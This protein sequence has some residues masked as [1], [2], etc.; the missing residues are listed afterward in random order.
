MTIN[1]ISGSVCIFVFQKY[2]LIK[3]VSRTKR[4][5]NNRSIHL[6]I[7]LFFYFQT[8][9]IM[10]DSWVN[11][12][13]FPFLFL[14]ENVSLHFCLNVDPFS[15]PTFNMSFLFILNMTFFNTKSFSNLFFFA[16]WL[17][18]HFSGSL[19]KITSSSE[20]LIIV[21]W[22]ATA[23][24]GWQIDLLSSSFYSFRCKQH[25]CLQI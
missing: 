6:E 12:F 13:I 1:K 15:V 11:H 20:F 16:L 18:F 10:N 8:N 2:G 7:M 5:L 19:Q 17:V 9:R 25:A 4:F 3:L 24:N 14:R 23:R 22:E 21:I